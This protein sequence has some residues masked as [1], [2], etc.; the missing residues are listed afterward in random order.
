MSRIKIGRDPYLLTE[1]DNVM[2]GNVSR[3]ELICIEWKL[4][5]PHPDFNID[6]ADIQRR[7]KVM[8][9]EKGIFAVSGQL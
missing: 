6:D 9:K 1:E 7:K 8:K 2:V 5:N 3:L 4:H